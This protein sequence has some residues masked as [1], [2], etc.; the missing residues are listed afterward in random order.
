MIRKSTES[1][2]NRTQLEMVTLDELVPADHLVRKIE[3]VIDFE[4]IYPL[5][6]DLYSEDRGRP[7]VD[8]VVLIK[9]AF[10]QYLLGIRSMR[11]TIREIETNVA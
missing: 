6:E 5:V 8:P 1:E 3:A 10:L 2:I 11:Q 4:F 7:S 9:M